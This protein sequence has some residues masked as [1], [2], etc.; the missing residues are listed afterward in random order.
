M[1]TRRHCTTFNL[2]SSKILPDLDLSDG[3]PP[4][5]AGTIQSPECESRQLQRRFFHTGFRFP[6]VPTCVGSCGQTPSLSHLFVD[7]TCVDDPKTTSFHRP[8]A[9]WSG[10]SMS[11]R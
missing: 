5:G 2:V 11:A 7:A 1:S 9:T 4:T 6:R 10:S 8:S 3:T